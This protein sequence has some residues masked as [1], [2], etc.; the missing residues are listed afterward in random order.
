G[1]AL[2]PEL[3]NAA[4]SSVAQALGLTDLPAGAS[5]TSYDPISSG[6]VQLQKAAAQVATMVALASKGNAADAGTV[7]ANLAGQLQAANNT[8]AVL[9]LADASTVSKALVG[10]S[11]SDSV[12]S[13]I[14]DASSAIGNA[15]SLTAISTAQSQALDKT[16]PAAPSATCNAVTNVATPTLRVAFN[17]TATDGSAAVA[18][19]VI[20]INEGGLS[21]GVATLTASDIA[22]GFKNVVLSEALPEGSHSLR[23]TLTDQGGNASVPS[24]P[25]SITVDTTAPTTPS[26]ALATD[27]GASASDGITSSGVVN[28]IGLEV[29]ASWQYST[30]GGGN[31]TNGSGNSFTLNSD[32][33][34]LVIVRQTDA[35]GNSSAASPA[36]SF[37]LDSAAPSA[38][39]TIT[40]AADNVEPTTGNVATGGTTNDQTLDLS[41]SL[42]AALATGEKVVIYDGLTAIGSANVTDLG[43]TFTTPALSNTSHSLSARVEDAAGNRGAASSGYSVTVNATVPTATATVTSITDALGTIT[44]PVT[45]GGVTNDVAPVIAGT[46]TGTLETGAK[47]VV[48]DNGLR[49]LGD[50]TVSGS[51][52]T[53]SASSLVQG[54]H[55]FRAVVENPGGNQGSPSAARSVIVDTSAPVAPTISVVAGDDVINAAEK[56]AGVTLTGTT[57]AGASVMVNGASANVSGT[58]WTYTLG[59]TAINGFGEGPETLTVISTDVA[60]NASTAATKTV[61]I[62][63]VG[64][65]TTLVSTA[66]AEINAAE[67]NASA[68][69]IG[70]TEAGARVSLTLGDGNVRS[71]IADGSGDWSYTLVK[72]DV[73]AI[74][75][76]VKKTLSASAIDISGNTGAAATT[77]VTI[78]TKAPVL[79]AFALTDDSDSGLKGDGKSN[80]ATPSITFTAEAGAKLALSTNGGGDFQ[81]ISDGTGAPQT[82]SVTPLTADGSY[83]LVLRATDAAGNVT[84]RTGSYTLDTQSPDKPT[85]GT[86][87]DDVGSIQGTLSQGAITDDTLLRISGN[88]E[89]F[90]KVA[91]FNGET[92][93][94]E[95][96][97][98]K[99][100]IWA[101]TTPA[102][103]NGTTYNVVAKATDAAGNVSET[104]AVRS[105][106][107]DTTPPVAPGLALASDT[108]VSGTD[109][110]TSSGV[111]NVGGLESGATWQYS[112]NGTQWIVGS[113]TSFTL[114][115]DGAKSVIVRQSDVAGNAGPASTPLQFTLDTT[116]AAPT[117]TLASDTGSSSS[118]KN[119]S[120]GLV[121]V[122]GLEAGAAWE[123]ST[124]SGATWTAGTGSSFTLSGDGAKAVQFR[125]T[126]LAGNTSQ[127]G[128]LSFTLDTTAPTTGT[129][130]TID[131]DS[132]A[133]GD[134]LTNDNTPVI[135]VTAEAGAKVG[136]GSGGI[137][138]DPT[139]YT[140]T[141]SQANPGKYTIT[142]TQAL[143]DGGYGVIVRDAAGNATTTFAQDGSDVATFRIDTAAPTAAALVLQS[144]TGSS[145]N[146]GITNIGTVNVSGLEAG[147][148][149]QYSTNGGGT[150]DTGSGSNFVLGAGNYA[151]GA[152]QVR[153]T[154]KAGNLESATPASI[155]SAITVDQAGPTATVQV[156]KTSLKAG[157]TAQV[158]LTFNE[159][160]TGLDSTD[161]TVQGGTLGALASADGGKTWTATLTPGTA[162]ESASNTITLANTG[163]ADLAGNAGSGNTA[164]GIFVVDTKAP[165]LTPVSPADNGLSLGLAADLVLGANESLTKGAGNVSLF[166]A[167]GSLV[168]SL[169]V[170]SNR[171][172]I[173]GSGAQ[174]QIRIDPSADLVKDQGYYVT[175]SAGAFLDTAGNPAAGITNATTWN[176]TGAGATVT[177]NTVSGDNRINLSESGQPVNVSGT[178]SA[179]AAILAAFTTQ[180]LSVVLRPASGTDVALSGA[181]YSYSAGTVANW[182]AILPASQVAGIGNYTLVVTITGH[183]GAA[184]NVTGIGTQSVQVDTVVTPPIAAV[185]QDTGTSNSDGITNNGT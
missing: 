184:T 105:L 29:G 13:S 41:G 27:S 7:V 9:N 87:Q 103:D 172:T 48:Y 114:S 34:K 58:T 175:V 54:T 173:T 8:G 32:G 155:A 99:N 49:L 16:P 138:V 5:L 15:T 158:T 60:G 46:I 154:D 21:L 163:V 115:G 91:V 143:V 25:L 145:A 61:F 92:R 120:S 129:I 66:G 106:T 123:Y 147:A 119:T 108:G 74:G 183:T 179:E 12:Q 126:D 161:L 128:I 97:A 176:F 88:A 133:T 125:Q 52:W 65:T 157:D 130:T 185:A 40:G 62:D 78:D 134:R 53:F 82:I 76:D 168:E 63:T 94:A 132:G 159:K 11:A 160:I 22:A 118:D 164:S 140:V 101:L 23:V 151:A 55:S 35:A 98:D 139:K 93:L 95:V 75:Q 28:V 64:P 39:A 19:D 116:A 72:A 51:N 170:S 165:V 2:T 59:T 56:S 36:L 18:G 180:D 45:N 117:A 113:G 17:T 77:D 80:V 146:D 26:L 174:T 14:A 162:L 86:I 83:A 20:G 89:A 24:S 57:E 81:N 71:V 182:S 38:R 3:I 111:I 144:D 124:N 127:P 107:I 50:A 121:N 167:N 150:W 70:K 69:L 142:V 96:F 33:A 67:L 112:T 110:I 84:L 136:L 37:T 178:V 47:V 68:K 156:S 153:Q 166:N 30:D 171:V 137:A 149:W 177:V 31:W 10:V 4:A 43:W 152:V 122:T 79:T 42:S 6:N 148:T 141:E 102:L 109:K 44:G 73:A 181:S 1:G 135:S 131:A 85:I 90:S 104:S 169:D 100:G